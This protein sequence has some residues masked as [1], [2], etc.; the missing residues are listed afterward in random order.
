MTSERLVFVY[1]VCLG[2]LALRADAA[3]QSPTILPEVAPMI[4]TDDRDPDHNA[5][6]SNGVRDISRIVYAELAGRRP[7]SLDLYLPPHSI[8]RPPTGFPL[9]VYIHGG[10]WSGG[11]PRHTGPFADFPG[12]LAS[13]S[14]RGYV[15]AS[16]EYRLSGEAT[17]P[18]AISDVKSSIRWLRSHAAL[19]EIDS[20]RTMTWGVSSGAH[21]AALAAVSC[22]V[23]ALETISTRTA[24]HDAKSVENAVSDVSD[25]VQGSV[26]WYGVFNMA[27]I[28]EQARQDKAMSRD[29]PDA[30]EWKFLGCISS[31]CKENELATASPVTYVDARDPPM[32]LIV[33]NEDRV[34][35]Y[36]QTLEMANRLKQFGVTYELVVLP[37]TGHSF[38]GT[39]PEQTRNSN[40]KALTETFRFFDRY[41]RNTSSSDQK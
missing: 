41:L 31:E 33:G 40:L 32:L 21:L 29:N 23:P 24:S 13:L 15:V 2:F 20:G 16:I 28:A 26:S 22:D 19:Y 3:S 39:S 25:C 7:L 18:A 6:F 17:F 1:S 35:P 27:S 30:P 12:V 8:R 10:G 38:V 37:G 5:S 14:A 11:D 34:V 4:A 9:V 36:H